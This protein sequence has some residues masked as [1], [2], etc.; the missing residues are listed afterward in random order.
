[1]S[2]SWPH[3]AHGLVQ[4]HPLDA[5]IVTDG[6]LFKSLSLPSLWSLS[7]L[8]Q[9]LC[10]QNCSSLA[11]ICFLMVEN[12]DNSPSSLTLPKLCQHLQYGVI[13][14][15]RQASSFTAGTSESILL[16][17]PRPGSP[18]RFSNKSEPIKRLFYVPSRSWD[19]AGAKAWPW[20]QHILLG[21]LTASQHDWLL[22]PYPVVTGFDP[23]EEWLC[24]FWLES[25]WISVTLNTYYD[26]KRWLKEWKEN[27]C[28]A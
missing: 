26:M 19:A 13:G 25:R 4:L 18:H 7:H 28:I 27:V 15:N 5:G 9:T 22:L 24:D 6:H 1:M 17:L 14:T 16:H 2:V 8:V 10:N 3:G 21:C 20:S 12:K 23:T 11:V